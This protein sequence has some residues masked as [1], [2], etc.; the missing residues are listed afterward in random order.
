MSC[1]SDFSRSPRSC[2]WSVWAVGSRVTKWL[3][4]RKISLPWSSPSSL[5]EPRDGGARYLTPRGV[6][7]CPVPGRN[8][9]GSESRRN[10]WV[11]PQRPPRLLCQTPSQS[12]PAPLHQ[13]GLGNSPYVSTMGKMT[14]LWDLIPSSRQ[15]VQRNPAL[16]KDLVSSTWIAERPRAPRLWNSSSPALKRH[17]R[18]WKS[19]SPS[20]VQLFATPWTIHS[21]EFSRPEYWSG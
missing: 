5:L 7:P 4:S 1:P 9:R 2:Q 10:E 11:T 13:P 21:V 6:L 20:H 15:S 17:G 8:N 19:K 14:Y 12:L 16:P 18:S 3:I